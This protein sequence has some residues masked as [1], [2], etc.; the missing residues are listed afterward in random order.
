MRMKNNFHIKACVPTLVLKQRPEGTR[1]W[2]II[3]EGS[4]QKLPLSSR[5]T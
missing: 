4:A 5:K 1:E 2:P 3:Q